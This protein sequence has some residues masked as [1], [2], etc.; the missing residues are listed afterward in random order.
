MEDRYFV[1]YRRDMDGEKE[2]ARMRKGRQIYDAYKGFRTIEE[3]L[4]FSYGH[5]R[6]QPALVKAGLSFEGS[7][8]VKDPTK[9]YLVAAYFDKKYGHDCYDG[10]YSYNPT[11]EVARCAPSELEAMLEKI[12]SESPD[13]MYLGVELTLFQDLKSGSAAASSASAAQ[14]EERKPEQ[15][16]YGILRRWD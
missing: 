11:H 9:P 8:A 12:G 3:A 10:S 4:D 2:C 7:E 6:E 15:S 5:L 14:V 1:M 16:N 13:K